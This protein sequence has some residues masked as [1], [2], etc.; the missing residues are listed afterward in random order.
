MLSY[1]S[2]PACRH[3]GDIIRIIDTQYWQDVIWNSSL[4]I[5]VSALKKSTQLLVIG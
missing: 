3:P 2:G 5:K 1:S 4:Q